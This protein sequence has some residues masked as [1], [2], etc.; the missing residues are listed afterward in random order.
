MSRK[1]TAQTAE[2]PQTKDDYLPVIRGG[3]KVE[4]LRGYPHPSGS[5][6]VKIRDDNP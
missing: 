3:N 2:R 4:Y 6:P 5:W 1:R